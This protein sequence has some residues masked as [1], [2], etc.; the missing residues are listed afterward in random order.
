MTNTNINKA[1]ID[2]VWT[3]E[4]LLRVVE[5]LRLVLGLGIE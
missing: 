5:S 2:L 3:E 1:K 4:V